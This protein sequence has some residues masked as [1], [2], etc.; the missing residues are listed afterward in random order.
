MG[1]HDQPWQECLF[2]DGEFRRPAAGGTIDV[3]DK[4]SGEIF[5]R[6]GLASAADT[7]SAVSTAQQAQRGWAERT[8]AERAALLRGVAAPLADRHARSRALPVLRSSRNKA[9][10]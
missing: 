9:E 5:G 7:D 1:S 8:Y 2:V 10:K 6:A 3:R 4:A